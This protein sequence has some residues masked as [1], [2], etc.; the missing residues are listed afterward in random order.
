MTLKS[1][2]TLLERRQTE[3]KLRLQ[4][5]SG[6]YTA[7][8]APH[9]SSTSSSAITLSAEDRLRLF[10]LE[11]ERLRASLKALNEQTETELTLI[12]SALLELSQGSEGMR[13]LTLEVER[14][15][16]E[17]RVLE[18]K[19]AAKDLDKSSLNDNVTRL[20]A[21][22]QSE[23][24]RTSELQ[25]R[26]DQ[27]KRD[28]EAAELRRGSADIEQLLKQKIAQLE[29][30]AKD[31]KDERDA[32]KA[33]NL[34]MEFR[35]KD[36]KGAAESPIKLEVKTVE[37]LGNPDLTERKIIEAI[38][39]VKEEMR[40][41]NRTQKEVL[42]RIREDKDRRSPA[43][44]QEYQA[45]RG[46]HM[47]FSGQRSWARH[48]APG[49]E[50][51]T[52]DP[53]LE[54]SLN[55]PPDFD[56]DGG[57]GANLKKMK[58]VIK[59]LTER[60]NQSQ[61]TVE[62]KT[63]KLKELKKANKELMREVDGLKGDQRTMKAEEAKLDAQVR[64]LKD[65][66]DRLKA[67]RDR[68]LE[69]QTGLQ[70]KVD[71]LEKKVRELK[72]SEQKIQSLEK[73]KEMMLTNNRERDAE[74]QSLRNALNDKQDALNHVMSYSQLNPDASQF[75]DSAAGLRARYLKLKRL[76]LGLREAYFR[77]QDDYAT[78]SAALEKE[79]KQRD[80][81]LEDFLKRSDFFEQK[82]SEFRD[83]HDRILDVKRLIVSKHLDS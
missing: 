70:K 49:G 48:N 65:E 60:F 58:Q 36:L 41:F 51:E 74:I 21:M 47:D 22:L 33:D 56:L 40:N 25:S 57:K 8:A 15:K 62:E 37:G 18:A 42:D 53:H 50:R 32:L 28:L 59:L 3:I 78:L 19:L 20:E 54:L 72:E 80:A 13:R 64:K 5:A 10:A 45:G 71:K 43:L 52:L 67:E 83:F 44:S 76:F 81:I 27:M 61:K 9:G 77:L 63:A 39:S 69:T 73:Q 24:S 68:G 75:D 23:R 30:T 17:K 12:N 4:E 55:L 7:K 66:L 11:N 14:L 82:I 6:I 34:R 2:A 1:L 79:V 35:I 16:E 31:L 46:R 29:R 38:G 26:L